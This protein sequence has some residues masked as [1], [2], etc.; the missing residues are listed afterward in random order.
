MKKEIWKPVKGY[1]GFYEVSNLGRVKSLERYVKSGNRTIKV[2]E[3]ILSICKMQ[4]K[5]GIPYYVV[6]LSKN[7]KPKTARLHRLVAEAFIPN[8][9]NK[10]C[11]N[12]IDYDTSNNEVSNLEW[13]THK[14]N[15]DHSYFRRKKALKGVN[16]KLRF[17]NNG[18]TGEH[19]IYYSKKDK[20]FRV[21]F[22]KS[23]KQ[24]YK[25]FKTLE[26]AK[27]WRDKKIEEVLKGE[28]Q[29]GTYITTKIRR[30]TNYRC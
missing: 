9:L 15:N 12:H 7:G 28:R 21:S 19:H 2:Y 25:E 24:Y 5:R 22:M 10:P 18:N 30:R 23:K 3:K 27:N 8:P 13:C 4:G 6:E 14:E 1:E 20:S 29:N 26:E 16:S 17:Y 11:V